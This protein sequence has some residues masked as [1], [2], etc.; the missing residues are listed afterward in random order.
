M[1]CGVCG[2]A[3]RLSPE[4]VL[5]FVVAK[6]PEYMTGKAFEHV[7]QARAD[8]AVKKGEPA[9]ELPSLSSLSAMEEMEEGEGV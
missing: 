3:P 5:A 4:S 9:P 6:L 8:E 7:A 1:T 2:V